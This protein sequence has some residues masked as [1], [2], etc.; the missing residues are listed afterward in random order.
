MKKSVSIIGGGPAALL[1]AVFLDSQKF[2]VTIYEKNKALGRKFMVAGKGGFNLTHSE[3]IAELI[4][5]LP[6]SGHPRQRSRIEIRAKLRVVADENRIH[7]D[8]VGR[9]RHPL[10]HPSIEPV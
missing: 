10:G 5:S 4:A 1:L 7:T 2:K 3:P 8:Y 6:T 9:S